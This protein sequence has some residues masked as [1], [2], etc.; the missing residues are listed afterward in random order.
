[1]QTIRSKHGFSLIEVVTTL[2]IVGVL[3][4]IVTPA[5]DTLRQKVGL[6]SA[7]REVMSV[8]YRTRGNALA[9]NAPRRLVFSPPAS[10]RV[11]DSNGTTT[12]FNENLDPYGCGIRIAT[13]HSI[14]VTYDA[15]GLL[16]PP[17][18]VTLTLQAPARESRTVTVYP[19][20]RPAAS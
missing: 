11:T 7:Q 15:R 8:L 20:G 18:T 5:V 14:T 1:M 3:C 17:T 6:L 10:V 19:T 9:S 2:S 12:Y 13:E 4:A 16:N